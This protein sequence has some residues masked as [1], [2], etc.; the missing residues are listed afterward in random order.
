MP[1]IRIDDLD[2][3]YQQSGSGPD[4]VLVHAF[5]SNLAVWMLT[6][7][8]GVLAEDFRVT[9]YDL[10]G[11]GLTTATPTGYASDNLARDFAKLH[12]H[13]ELNS[14][15]L[16]GHSY[17]GVIGL[18]AALDHPQRV[19]GVIVS[20]SYFPGLAELE[21]AMPHSEPWKDLNKAF[22]LVE[23]D[24]GETVD[25]QRLFEVVAALAPEEKKALQELMGPAASRWLSQMGQLAETA[26]GAEAF[27]VAG[28]TGERL[29]TVSQPV[30]ALYDEHTP[31]AATRDFLAH[32][33]ADCCVDVVPQAK[34]L[35]PVENSPEFISRVRKHLFRMA[36][37]DVTA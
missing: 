26:A 27:E 2:V 31:F 10:R 3:H 33:L 13:L 1:R 32:E 4:V 34:H 29:K 19:R 14:A 9:L 18:H 24:L 30:V 5:T 7:I 35:A 17:G 28:L 12:E 6:N 23:I 22:E 25:F 8:V 11:H 20:D 15:L 21:P 16:V 37:L 36:G